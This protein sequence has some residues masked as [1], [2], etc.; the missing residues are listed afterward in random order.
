LNADSGAPPQSPEV[1]QAFSG[2][3]RNPRTAE[4]ILDVK[5]STR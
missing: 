1:R 4:I 2:R 5:A 3:R